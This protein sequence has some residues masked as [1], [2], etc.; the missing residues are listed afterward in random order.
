M[1]LIYFQII[2]FA[3][4]TTVGSSINK[5]DLN[6]LYLEDYYSLSIYEQSLSLFVYIF[7]C[8][9]TYFD[10]WDDGDDLRGGI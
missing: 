2:I 9:S 4:I 8:H 5:R 1:S 7:P 6:A 3:V 10:I